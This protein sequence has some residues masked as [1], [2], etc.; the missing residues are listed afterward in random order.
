[1]LD[2][3]LL[4]VVIITRVCWGVKLSKVVIQRL[5]VDGSLAMELAGADYIKMYMLVYLN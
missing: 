5:V 2:G 4:M 3:D 1:M